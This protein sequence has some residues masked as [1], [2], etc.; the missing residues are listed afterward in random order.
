MKEFSL[1]EFKNPPREF[2]GMPFWSWNCKLDGEELARQI[3]EL[4]EMGFGGFFMHVRTGMD[5]P[6]LSDEY[7]GIVKGCVKKAKAEGMLACLYDEDR[8]SSGAA[9]GLVTK[10]EKYRQKYLLFTPWPYEEKG[11]METPG[12]FLSQP[13]RNGKGKLLARYVVILDGE[14]YLAKYR[15]LEEG[16]E[17]EGNIWYAYLETAGDNPWYNGQAYSDT[18]SKEAVERF[19]QVTHEKYKEWVGEDFGEAIPFVFTDEPQF[20]RKHTLDFA[21]GKKDVT[22]PWTD[23]C[24]ESYADKYGESLLAALPEL[25]WELPERKISRTRYRYHDYIAQRFA[26]AFACT[27]GRWCEKNGIGFTG[28]LMEEPTLESQCAAVGETMRSYGSFSLPGIDMLR[29]DL[30]YTT[31][32][33]A[34]SISRQNGQKGIS[35]ELYGVTGWDTDFRDYKFYGDWQAALGVVLRIPHLS[36]VSMKGEAKRDFPAT[37][38]YQSPWYKKFSYVEEHFARVN[39]AMARG[40]A[41][42]RIGVIHPIESFWLHWGPTEQTEGIRKRLDE[43]FQ[44]LTEWLL[45]GGMDFDFIC[46]S[47]L[48][49]QCAQGGLPF[50][51]GKMEYEA[52]I[53]PGCETLRRSTVEWLEAFKAAGGY[54]VF[55][56]E[57]PSWMDGMESARPENLYASA[58]A[59]PFE[60]YALLEELKG[61]REVEI[62][63]ENGMLAE[64]MLYQMREEAGQ[65]GIVRWLFIARGK[66]PYNKDMGRRRKIRIKIRGGYIPEFLDTVSGECRRV[67]YCQEKGWTVVEHIFYD[68]DS[69]LL[70]LNGTVEDILWKASGIGEPDG[71]SVLGTEETAINPLVEYV[72]GEPN[73]LVLDKA[74]YYLAKDDGEQEITYEPETELLRADGNI[75][76]SLGWM[77]R[78][79]AIPQPWVRKKEK[80]VHRLYLRFTI[81]SEIDCR[82]VWL[83]MEEV[84]SAYIIWNGG[85]V[86]KKPD[87]GWYTDRAIRKIALPGLKMGKNVLELILPFGKETNTEWCYLLGAFGVRMMGEKKIITAMPERVGFGNLTGQGFPFYG[88]SIC[89]RIPFWTKGGNAYVRIPHYRS[90]VL[91]VRVDELGRKTIAYPPYETGLGKIEEGEHMLEVTAYI[92]RYNAFG[93]LHQADA[94]D[95]WCGPDAWRTQGDA[96]TD[97]YRLASAGLLSAPVITVENGAAG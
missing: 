24:E 87:A 78:G 74:E 27:Y 9:G 89:Y 39:M 1:D 56:G 90:A 61:F 67:Y 17:G 52:I 91:E 64:D 46:E 88:G 50:A 49:E 45:F 77:V 26:E 11:G 86:A 71:E 60:R 29:R 84:Q 95:E 20:A 6:Y 38:G 47:K 21:E 32:K 15:M 28:H 12:G 43:N 54:L 5:T 63:E 36:W 79:A 73:V 53:V 83:A 97:S 13:L 48:P 70:R 22:M 51:V 58:R 8:W 35:S 33:Q 3:E 59:I 42:A 69:V 31:A 75:R 81:E 82:Q 44:N 25:F 55:M 40:K 41:I 92:S 23:D 80:A 34:Q 14:G 7:M 76:K 19:L 2:R 66:R 30:E 18:L 62:R 85:E 10:E 94:K 4:K 37:F 72:L 96:W 57:A 16:D 65:G 93:P 68:Y